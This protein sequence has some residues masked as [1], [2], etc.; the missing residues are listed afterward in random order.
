MDYR[1]GI[2]E[3]ERNNPEA[4]HFLLKAYT[5]VQKELHLPIYH[6]LCL[7]V[8]SEIFGRI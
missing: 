6:C 2:K 5:E 8:E 3:K 7:M 4:R 1:E